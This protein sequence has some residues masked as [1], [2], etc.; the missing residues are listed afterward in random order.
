MAQSGQVKADVEL[1][2]AYKALADQ[3]TI[4]GAAAASLAAAS[5]EQAERVEKLEGVVKA[6]LAGTAAGK[7]FQPAED[8]AAPDVDVED[9]TAPLPASPAAAANN[10]RQK[11]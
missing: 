8:R 1:D 4:L 3:V 2:A 11:P 5:K 6:G 10:R 9:V 7:R